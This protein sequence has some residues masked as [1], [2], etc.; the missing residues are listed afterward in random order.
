MAVLVLQHS[1]QNASFQQHHEN[2]VVVRLG[3]LASRRLEFPKTGRVPQRMPPK[4]IL[5][6]LAWG[7]HQRRI[8][9]EKDCSEEATQMT[10]IPICTTCRDKDTNVYYLWFT[11]LLC[12]HNCFCFRKLK[13]LMLE[14]KKHVRC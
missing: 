8:I 14:V 2:G 6:F 7:H 13:C 5:Y 1:K 3:M 11:F 9:R 10:P 12:I 4:D